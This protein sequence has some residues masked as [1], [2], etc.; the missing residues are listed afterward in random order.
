MYAMDGHNTMGARGHERQDAAPG[1]ERHWPVGAV[2]MLAIVLLLTPA[3]IVADTRM[4]QDLTTQPVA[5]DRFLSV[6]GKLTPRNARVLLVEGSTDPQ[7]HMLTR[8]A[9]VL[10][11]RAV[12]TYTVSP[13]RSRA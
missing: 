3:A 8:C 1:R 6:V 2:V 10:Y 7:Y 12:V 11:P 5:F 4:S 13:R 9:Y